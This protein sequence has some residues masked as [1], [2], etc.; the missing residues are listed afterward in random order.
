M[1]VFLGKLPFSVFLSK[2]KIEKDLKTFK[3]EK[4]ENGDEIYSRK[5]YDS[6]SGSLYDK[7][8]YH[9]YNKQLHI[10]EERID[11]EYEYEYEY[12]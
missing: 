1:F 9:E 7:A 10:F 5:I 11:F 6:I 2:L 12:E 3:F 4:I 8:I